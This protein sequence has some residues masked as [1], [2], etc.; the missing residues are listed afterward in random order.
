MR[1]ADRVSISSGFARCSPSLTLDRVT[2]IIWIARVT[3]RHVVVAAHMGF[4]P[5]KNLVCDKNLCNLHTL[6][7]RH[8]GMNT[9]ACVLSE[10][11]GHPFLFDGAVFRLLEHE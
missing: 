11:G 4:D 5:V 8:D 2:P 9:G 6:T 10:L 7:S 3:L 1:R